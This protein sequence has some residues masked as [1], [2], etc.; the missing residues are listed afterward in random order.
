MHDMT[1]DFIAEWEAS[2]PLAVSLFQRTWL[3][4][5]AQAIVEVLP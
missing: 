1:H 3:A 4:L 5:I 2:W